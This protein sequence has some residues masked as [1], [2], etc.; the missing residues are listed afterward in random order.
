VDLTRGNDKVLRLPWG[1]QNEEPFSVGRVS[2]VFL[3]CLGRL[4][5]D[6]S[7]HPFSR[8]VNTSASR[9]RSHDETISS[10]R[11]TSIRHQRRDPKELR[12]GA[13]PERSPVIAAPTIQDRDQIQEVR[14]WTIDPGSARPSSPRTDSRRPS[15]SH[16][17][18][19]AVA[20][21]PRAPSA[22]ADRD[23]PGCG[24]SIGIMMDDDVMDVVGVPNAE[25]FP[26]SVLG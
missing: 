11:L 2:H 14:S 18:G 15:R 26:S 4:R 8:K 13:F 6:E 5:P 7:L 3:P 22:F 25:A 1:S 21:G 10:I 20:A 24:A 16:V 12:A 17:S 23:G 19:I 9:I